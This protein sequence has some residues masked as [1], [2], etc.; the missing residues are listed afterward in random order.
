MY[1]IAKMNFE[2]GEVDK[3]NLK[4]SGQRKHWQIGIFSIIQ[5]YVNAISAVGLFIAIIEI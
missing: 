4:T 3:C 5:K 2:S 1:N